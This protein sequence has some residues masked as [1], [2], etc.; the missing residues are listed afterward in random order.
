MPNPTEEDILLDFF[1]SL[2]KD[3]KE[4]TVLRMIFE[5]LSEDEIIEKLIE[6]QP[7]KRT[8]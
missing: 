7:L 2:I 3:Q 8:E 6:Y 1:N 5:N 4:Q